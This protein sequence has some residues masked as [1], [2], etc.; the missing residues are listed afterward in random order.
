MSNEPEPERLSPEWHAR[1]CEAWAEYTLESDQAAVSGVN[2]KSAIHASEVCRDRAAKLRELQACRELLAEIWMRESYEVH[3]GRG[4]THDC[5][6]TYE[7]LQD[8]L[9][10]CGI[11]GDDGLL[12]K[13]NNHVTED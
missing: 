3:P 5:T 8:Y 2:S 4:R 11:I 1:E 12:L 9:T 10:R 7:D 13:E 6:S